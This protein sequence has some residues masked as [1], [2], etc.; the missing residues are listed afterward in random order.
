MR[1]Y[2]F[3]GNLPSV[4]HAQLSLIGWGGGHGLWHESALG[5]NGENICYEPNGQ[6]RESMITDVR[7]LL[8]CG[9]DTDTQCQEYKWTNNVGGGH[10]LLYKDATSTNQ[11]QK[12]VQ[13]EMRSI[14][15]VISDVT[16]AGLSIDGAISTSARV[17]LL[18][19]DAFVKSVHRFRYTVTKNMTAGRLSF[20]S[21]GAD[22]YDENSFEGVAF[23]GSD[24]DTPQLVPS[25]TSFG[26][27]EGYPVEAY[28]GKPCPEQQGAWGHCWFYLPSARKQ[29]KVGAFADRGLVVRHWDAVLGGQRVGQ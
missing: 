29:G 11:Y 12:Q 14:G 9:M 21:V 22:R 6:Q 7:P 3:Y 17:H 27:A 25:A 19:T 28:T 16:Y 13:A 1:R 15:P 18:Q 24:S 5:V 4:S 8:V 2:A 26:T 10:F 23:G 20:Y